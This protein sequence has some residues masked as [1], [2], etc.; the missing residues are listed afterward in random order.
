MLRSV[1]PGYTLVCSLRGGFDINAIV[2]ILRMWLRCWYLGCFCRLHFLYKTA[3]V[4][5]SVFADEFEM[6]DVEMWKV[7]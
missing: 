3:F 1:F 7:H 6:D 5:K 4:C 2:H